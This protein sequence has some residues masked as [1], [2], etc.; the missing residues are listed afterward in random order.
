MN[1]FYDI[2][3]MLTREYN[4]LTR[5]SKLP[6]QLS[7]S[8]AAPSVNYPVVR[9]RV[10]NSYVVVKDNEGQAVNVFYDRIVTTVLANIVNNQVG[11]TGFPL[12][13]NAGLTIRS[14]VPSINRAYGLSILPQEVVDGPFDPTTATS[15]TLTFT[16]GSLHFNNQGSIT[17][18]IVGSYKLDNGVCI[19]KPTVYNYKP[20]VWD[21]MMGS[22]SGTKL[23]L[24]LQTAKTDYSPVAHI[25]MQFRGNFYAGDNRLLTPTY[26]RNYAL[27]AAL[28]SVDGL[29]WNIT[30]V[31][32]EDFNLYYGW[33]M[34]NGPSATLKGL[35]VDLKFTTLNDILVQFSAD[36]VDTKY[37]RV[38]L[39][40]GS[41]VNRMY[42][43]TAI[44]HY[45]IGQ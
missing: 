2:V 41:M 33:I 1:I 21:E 34:Y 10:K 22:Q 14:I 5:K 4:K 35:L 23:S 3:E 37:D 6:S 31:D 27:I 29:P 43:K 32:M 17:F 12:M 19:I 36:M 8:D 24:M 7:F 42:T 25:L 44:I 13:S 11:R 40:A 30:S 28:K 18:P 26:P 39:I 9:Y 15:I 45:N 20:G 38:M 16:A